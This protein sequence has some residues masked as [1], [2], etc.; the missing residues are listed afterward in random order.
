MKFISKI[1]AISLLLF[2]FSACSDE[3]KELEEIIP[4]QEE[5]E[6]PEEEPEEK[7]EEPEEPE[8]EVVEKQIVMMRNA[9]KNV[10]AAAEKYGVNMRVA[11]YI[12]ALSSLDEAMK[13]RGMY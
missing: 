5:P 8:E 7:P 10:Y 9:F 13:V 6:K 12:V 2:C 3:T 1:I 4:P 11:A